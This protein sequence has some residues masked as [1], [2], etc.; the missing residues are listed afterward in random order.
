[1]IAI[2]ALAAGIAPHPKKRGTYKGSSSQGISE[3]VRTPSTKRV[4]AHLEVVVQCDGFY[5][6]DVLDE[7][8]RL[9][10]HRS[11][12][13]SWSDT[14]VDMPD[15]PTAGA[16]DLTGDFT[17]HEKGRFDRAKKH[18]FRR[19]KGTVQ[20]H[21][22]MKDGSGAVIHECDTDRVTYKAKLR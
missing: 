5:F 14:G 21:V 7:K 22:T 4:V 11:F 19:V 3:S 15:D 8:A 16:G 9:K 17:G 1:M 10:K 12:K 20:E 13:T 18:V 2:P 6:S